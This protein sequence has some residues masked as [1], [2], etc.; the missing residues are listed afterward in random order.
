[1]PEAVKRFGPWVLLITADDASITG[2]RFLDADAKEQGEEST[3]IAQCISELEE[4][5]AGTRTGF[6]V[7]VRMLGTPFQQSV[8][9]AMLEI[10]YGKVRTYGDVAKAIGK[11]GAAR[12]VGA[13]CGKNPVAVIVTGH[14]VVGERDMGGYA[15][16]TA[17]KEK[18]L[19]LE[20]KTNEN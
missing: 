13:A 12:A 2:I 4:Y 20:Q 3:L 18:L 14:R 19:E 11:P 8:W 10:P 5:F 15:W 17:R 16:G 9:Q 6:S 7:P 1:M